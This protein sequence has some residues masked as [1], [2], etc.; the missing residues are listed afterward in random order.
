MVGGEQIECVASGKERGI[1]TASA[2]DTCLAHPSF[3]N[4][5]M[6]YE[7]LLCPDA[8]RT[9]N[10]LPATS[11]SPGGEGRGEGEPFMPRGDFSLAPPRPQ[12]WVIIALLCLCFTTLTRADVLIT[13]DGERFVGNIVEDRNDHVIFKSDTAGRFKIA[14]NRIR[15]LYHGSEP[16]PAAKSS[17]TASVPPPATA[18]ATTTNAADLGWHPPGLGTDGFDWIQLKSGEWLKG[19]LDYVQDKRVQFESD[20]LEDLTLKLK[21]VRQIYPGVP[22]YVKFDGQDQ[23]YGVVTLSNDVVMVIGQVPI[24]MP[25]WS[26]TGITPG[27]KREIDFWT[28][29]ISLGLNLQEGNTKQATLNAAAELARRTPA[30]QLLLNYLGNFSTVNSEQTANNH[31]FNASYDIRLSRDWF[32]RP[33]QIEYYRDQLANIAH[34]VTAAVALGYYFFDRDNLE[35]RVAAGPGYQYS[36]F[37]TVE[38]GADDSKSTPALT[39]QTRFK[40]DITSRLTFIQDFSSTLT[41][42]EAGLYNHHLVTTLEFEIKRHLDLDLSFVWD[43]L[44]NPQTE[45]D[46]TVPKHSDLR[47]TM[48][49][50]IRF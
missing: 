12:S 24:E 8:L 44:R 26:L 20:K 30:T 41:S 16:T 9:V 25:R 31:R 38:A 35:W 15:E 49:I 10:D 46:G 13:K 34:R 48:G 28:A 45:S 3:P 29:R 50:G 18:S 47:L 1:H 39:F 43:Y 5:L 21:D 2:D 42:Q 4:P 37:E 11:P 19:H 32:V 27:G 36:R 14:R 7:P 40:A 22:M 17:A 6:D 23:V 33:V